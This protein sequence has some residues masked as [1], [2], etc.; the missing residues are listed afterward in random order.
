LLLHRA[1]GFLPTDRPHRCAGEAASSLREP[2]FLYT[3]GRTAGN[4]RL[5]DETALW[6][7]EAVTT[8]RSLGLTLTEIADL[9]EAYL[10]HRTA[11][12]V[13]CSPS[14]SPRCGSGPGPDGGVAA[15]QERI[16]RFEAT[17]RDMLAGRKSFDRT[18]AGAAGGA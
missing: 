14:A 9:I 17:Q 6:C 18:D 11:T 16:D 3:V 13:P 12:S 5:F 7:V 15:G 8:L 2:R 1:S 4:Y 10:T